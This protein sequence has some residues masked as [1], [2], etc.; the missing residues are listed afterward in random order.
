MEKILNILLGL[1]DG[2]VEKSGVLIFDTPDEFIK[3]LKEVT[4]ND[5]HF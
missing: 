1:E 2:Q 4:K 5:K 3:V